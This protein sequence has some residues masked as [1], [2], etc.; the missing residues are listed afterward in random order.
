M[1][2]DNLSD[3]EQTPTTFDE[4]RD[5]CIIQKACVQFSFREGFCYTSTRPRLGNASKDTNS[6]SG[7]LTGRI[8][9]MMET[10]GLCRAPEY[11]D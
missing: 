2:W 4:C 1:S 5:L 8:K 3:E 9:T 11:G 6:A 7:W 10:K